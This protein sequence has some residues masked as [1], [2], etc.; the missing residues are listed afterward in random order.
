MDNEEEVHIVRDTAVQRYGKR[1][2]ELRT[3]C[4]E[5]G[6]MLEKWGVYI[7]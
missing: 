3:N 5:L 7:A 6:R 1:C 2:Q 4:P